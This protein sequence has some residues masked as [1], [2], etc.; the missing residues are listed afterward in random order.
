MDILEHEAP[1]VRHIPI[2]QIRPSSERHYFGC[3][4][5]EKLAE[6]MCAFG[7]VDPIVVK[8]VSD[9]Y[10]IVSGVRRWLAARTLG[11]RSLNAKI[12]E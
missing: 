11:W 1:A 2:D 4:R 12:V 10:E 5:I 9:G 3:D 8:R 6:W 7:L